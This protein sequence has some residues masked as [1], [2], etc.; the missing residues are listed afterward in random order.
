MTESLRNDLLIRACR[1]EPV[2]R[3]PVWIM[4]QAGRY[5]PEYQAVRAK[6]DFMT[7]CRTPEL[8]AEVTLQ[9]VEIIGVDGAIIF[10]DIL[11]IPAA[12]GMALHFHEGRGPVFEKPLR[13]QE[14]FARLEPLQPQEQLAYVLDA[15]KLVRKELAGQVPLIGF[16][17]APWT[18]AAYM[19]EGHGSRN[20]VE[21]K[22]LMYSEPALLH[23]L[24]DRLS[25]AVADF[26]CAQI[27]AG[28]QVVQ[29]FDSWAGILTPASF[30]DFSLPYLRKVVERVN[31]Q[32]A[33]V[34]VF[35][36]DAG[37]SFDALADIGADVLGVSW[38]ED[39]ALARR[40]VKGRVALQGNLD[41]CVLF[42]RPEV[43]EQEVRKVLNKAGRGPGH[44]FNLGHGI[45]PET[46]VE[47]ARAL[48]EFVARH[49]S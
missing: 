26:L 7:M 42:S 2:E 27:A 34:I 23:G 24:L 46:P 36:R 49:S 43:I 3:T 29:I 39:L 44:I 25:D 6:A 1:Q 20:F 18:L 47:N 5:L 22:R 40:A 8:A 30:R 16:A 21:I 4:R 33:P 32:G 38:T 17:G 12:M 31:T 28:A 15:L 9:P 10:S 13:K 48:V 41:P 35:A 14:D 19:V 37:H 11:V 45:L